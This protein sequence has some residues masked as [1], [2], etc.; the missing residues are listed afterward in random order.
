MNSKR[1]KIILVDQ[2]I[3]MN[4]SWL[5]R[6]SDQGLEVAVLDPVELFVE[7]DWTRY[8]EDVQVIN[9]IYSRLFEEVVVNR[10]RLVCFWPLDE[11][12]GNDWFD[13]TSLCNLHLYELELYKENFVATDNYGFS[14]E[15]LKA[16]KRFVY[17][18][19][20]SLLEDIHS[21]EQFEEIATLTGEKGSIV[22]FKMEQNGYVQY[23]YSA[24]D[25]FLDFSFNS[26]H[27]L[28]HDGNHLPLF[29]SFN[30]MLCKLSIQSD[31]TKY[32]T[33]F[34]DKHLEKAFFNV[35]AKAFKTENL[36]QNWLDSYSLN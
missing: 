28:K 36:I 35:L 10:K 8:E 24:T 20:E 31:L 27:D 29:E 21:N 5:D 14:F 1:K 19:I 18:L 12:Y 33:K 2:H 11:Q 16:W 26:V 15:I 23:A 9:Q 7:I 30:E 3:E 4:P 6:F 13:L 22:L 17:F 32:R 25:C 34:V